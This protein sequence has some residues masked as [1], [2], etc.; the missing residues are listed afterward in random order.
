MGQFDQSCSLAKNVSSKERVNPCF[1]WLLILSCHIFQ[2]NFIETP[3][4]VENLWRISLLIL[5]I[6]MNF[7]WFSGFFLTFHCY[8]KTNNVSSLQMMS[9]F[10]YFR[11]ALNRLFNNLSHNISYIDILIL[12]KL[13]LKY[14]VGVRLTLPPPPPATPEKTTLKNPRLVR[15]KLQDLFY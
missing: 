13:F 11:H 4:V 2:E 8:K 3:Q 6:F 10:F 9:A 7:H 12:G 15:V 5:A 14:E 1:L